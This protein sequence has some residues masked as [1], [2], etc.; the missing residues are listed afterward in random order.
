MRW[1]S[2][3]DVR[4]LSAEPVRGPSNLSSARPGSATISVRMLLLGT[5]PSPAWPPVSSLRHAVHD[6]KTLDSS[7]LC[8]FG[9]TGRR[10]SISVDMHRDET[11]R[12][13]RVVMVPKALISVWLRSWRMAGSEP[14]MME[15]LSSRPIQ[16]TTS[17]YTQFGL[18][19]RAKD[20]R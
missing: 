11:R 8:D 19:E 9:R 18:E 14:T 20:W 16:S 2:G 13:V 10:V 15:P 3:L 4:P 7:E 1:S 12:A 6:V 17:V 5:S